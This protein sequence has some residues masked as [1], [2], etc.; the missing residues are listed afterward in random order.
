MIYQKTIST[1]ITDYATTP[2]RTILEVC[3]GLVYKVE[4]DFPTGPASLLK[5]QIYDGSHQVWPST[6][7]EFFHSDGFCIS[8]DDTLLKLAA[9]FQY[10]IYTWNEC[11]SWPH[12]VTV[13]IGMVSNE[14]YIARFLPSVAYEQMMK[15]LREETKRQ[16]AEKEAII[17]T[18]FSWIEESKNPN[19]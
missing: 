14:I 13:R 17:E 3:K 8:F 6:P 2:K 15:V 11:E 4:I 16:E 1:I 19:T 7:G 9:P 18:P 12:S 10:N 5:V